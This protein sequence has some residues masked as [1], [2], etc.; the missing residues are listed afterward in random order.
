MITVW[1]HEFFQL[2]FGQILEDA[3]DQ[4]RKHPA[5]TGEVDVARGIFEFLEH[6]CLPLI[7]T[8]DWVFEASTTFAEKYALECF[9]HIRLFGKQAFE[10][11]KAL[12]KINDAVVDFL[13]HAALVG[14]VQIDIDI[15]KA[16]DFLALLQQDRLPPE[17]LS[18]AHVLHDQAV[19]Q[20]ALQMRVTLRGIASSYAEILPR[21][22]FVLKRAITVLEGGKQPQDDV[23]LIDVS[24]GLKW[25][26]DHIPEDHPLFPVLGSELR[27][28]YKV[29][30]NVANHPEGFEWH[31]EANEVCLRDRNREITI[32]VHS[33]QQKYRWFVVYLCDYGMRGIL[34][35]FCDR[36]RGRIS[37]QLVREYAKTFPED[38]P[39]GQE[40][41]VKFY[42]A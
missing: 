12:H 10:A 7:H 5:N 24:E 21:I 30:R 31:P 28:F 13:A 23:G 42:P 16:S 17:M 39:P 15:P 8:N 27:D 37:N 35:A 22:M 29:A 20:E 18:E 14:A 34:S 40:G 4:E 33:F 25:F 9:Y 19:D 32:H 3:K 41:I 36:E 6:K 38:F 11:Q 1:P 2:D 26:E